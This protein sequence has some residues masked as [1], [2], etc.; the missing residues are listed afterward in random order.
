MKYGI[1]GRG[2]GQGLVHSKQFSFDRII[3][4]LLFPISFCLSPSLWPQAAASVTFDYL[5]LL[6]F[7][8]FP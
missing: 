3:S 4:S 6:L 1:V 8:Y 7:L 2:V 5:L